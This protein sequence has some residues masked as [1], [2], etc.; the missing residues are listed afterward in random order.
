[1]P[2]VYGPFLSHKQAKEAGQRYY[3][4]GKPCKWGHV[5]HRRTRDSSCMECA[6]VWRRNWKK[7]EAGIES[8]RQRRAKKQKETLGAAIATA[9]VNT[10]SQC[11]SI[12][13]GTNKSKHL[14]AKTTQISC[15]A[16]NIYFRML[17]RDGMSWDNY[18]EVWHVDH[19]RPKS[20]FDLSDP[21]QFKLCH[22]WYNLQPLTPEENSD[23]GESW[24]Q[25]QEREWL[26][27]LRLLGYDGPTYCVTS[28]PR[29]GVSL[30][31]PPC[32][33]KSLSA[34]GR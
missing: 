18:G 16:L 8:D 25:K 14:P 6:K 12:K 7:T 31:Q 28:H 11:R 3:F 4:T 20:S 9:K 23:K 17:F 13:E 5:A 29:A 1:M 33:T 34:A 10:S 32:C 26:Q 21:E 19:I 24:T 27:H 30:P 2:P 15:E 22:S